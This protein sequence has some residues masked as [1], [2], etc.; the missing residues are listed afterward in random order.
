MGWMGVILDGRGGH[1]A[2][3]IPRF[4]LSEPARAWGVALADPARPSWFCEGAGSRLPPGVNGGSGGGIF[5][6]VMMW[7][8]M[9]S[10]SQYRTLYEP[11]VAI[12]IKKYGGRIFHH[13]VTKGVKT[14]E[15]L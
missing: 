7:V 6:F 15:E 2:R 3:F 12:A 9:A 8:G 5:I 14:H 11:M 1:F 13:E 4:A 10:P